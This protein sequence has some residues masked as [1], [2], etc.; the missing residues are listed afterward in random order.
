MPYTLLEKTEI[1]LSSLNKCK[2]DKVKNVRE[3]A[4]MTINIIKDLMN[5]S[6][7]QK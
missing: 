1:I 7:S 2:Y 4:M 6:E 5:K 3:A